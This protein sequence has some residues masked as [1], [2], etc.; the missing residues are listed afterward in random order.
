MKRMRQKKNERKFFT[1]AS[2]LTIASAVLYCSWPLGILLNP[3]AS[4][5]GLASE[6]GA[7]GQPYN[8]LFIWGDIVSGILLVGAV[9]VL[10]RMYELQGWSKLA[11]L[12]LA[13]YGICGACDASLPMS[14]LP[15]EHACGPVL[16][17]PM[18]IIHGIFDLTGSVALFGTLVVTAVHVHINSKEWKMWIYVIGL[19]GT[20]FAVASGVFYVWGGPGYW[21][22][23]YY[24]TLSC[25]WVASIPFVHRPKHAMIQLLNN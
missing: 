15:S 17:D 19:A 16:H 13:L 18:L 20:L 14:C 8:W 3:L 11:L 2:I 1:V 12:L 25:I 9:F 4:R 6:L 21:A 10:I 24:I 5:R 22:Q 7:Y 23:R